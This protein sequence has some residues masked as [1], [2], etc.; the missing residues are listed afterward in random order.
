M[1]K[2]T[3]IQLSQGSDAWLE[4]RRSKIGASDA[5]SIMGCGYS[6]LPQLY[7]QKVNGV[8]VF[9]N[10]AMRRGNEMEEE[11]RRW[12]EEHLTEILF[13]AVYQHHEYEWMT[14]SLDGINLEGTVCVEIK[15][16]GEKTH[17]IAKS[18]EIPVAHQ[19][20]MLHQMEVMGLDKMYYVSYVPG[21]PVIIEFERDNSRIGKMIEKENSFYLDCVASKI[22]PEDSF[23]TEDDLSEPLVKDLT[24]LFTELQVERSKKKEIEE[25][26]KS[27]IGLIRSLTE[28]RSIQLGEFK[29][30]KYAKKGTVQYKN[31]E[32]LKGVDLEAYRSASTEAWRVTV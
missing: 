10:N 24:A 28:D 11:A 14:A 32:A 3:L 12:T 17:S 5:P 21:D 29:A 6:S 15:C 4:F 2:P 26:E 16:P 27:L 13:P 25:K 22:R 19:W 18:G 9:V 1:N 31:I 30:T 23:L 8:Q 20:Q 7:D